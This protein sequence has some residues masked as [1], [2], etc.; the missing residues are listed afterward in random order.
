MSGYSPASY[1]G[2]RGSTQASLC[3]IFGVH[4]GTGTGFTPITP[5]CSL[6]LSF[7]QHYIFIF[8]LMLL[9]FK[10]TSRQNLGTPK[11]HSLSEIGQ[12]WI[13]KYFWL[14]KT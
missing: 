2:G 13:Q 7:S 5:V 11:K 8:I 4:S 6:S 14:F 10:W 12:H 9:S 3:E 1:H